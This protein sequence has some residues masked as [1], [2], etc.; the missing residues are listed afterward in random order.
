M[1]SAEGDAK[2]GPASSGTYEAGCHC[3]Y[4]KFRFAL[5]P[6]LPEYRVLQCNCSACTKLGY[7]L[8]SGD[9]AP[10]TS[11]TRSRKT[12][13]CSAE[14]TQSASSGYEE[15]RAGSFVDVPTSQGNTETG[16][17]LLEQDIEGEKTPGPEGNDYMFCPKCGTSIGIDF[18]DVHKPHTYG[19]NATWSRATQDLRSYLSASRR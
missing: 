17:H 16:S 6:P 4:V 5:S 13:L 1:S 7:L 18:R 10:S 14:A 9:D 15:G 3:G 19:I 12:R 8:V 11:S 2:Q